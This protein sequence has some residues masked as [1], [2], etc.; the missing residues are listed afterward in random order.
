MQNHIVRSIRN[1][2]IGCSKLSRSRYSLLFASVAIVVALA[3]VPSTTGAHDL[4]AA[5]G[6]CIRSAA[7]PVKS[8]GYVSAKVTS[9]AAP[10]SMTATR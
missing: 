8:G 3:F 1:H 6:A 7:K 10:T 9:T 4:K 5:H 2:G